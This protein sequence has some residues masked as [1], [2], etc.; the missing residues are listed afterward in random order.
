MISKIPKSVG[1]KGVTKVMKGSSL[2]WEKEKNTIPDSN[3]V[4]WSSN[5]EI[6]PYAN[7]VIV[8]REYQDIV[9]GKEIK[10]VELVGIGTITTGIK[11][12]T[13]FI[14]FTKSFDEILGITQKIPIDTKIIVTYK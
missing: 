5:K 11:N 7:V 12:N 9:R 4:S 13:P 6:S 1:N 10:S 8:P 3:S 14:S 2:V